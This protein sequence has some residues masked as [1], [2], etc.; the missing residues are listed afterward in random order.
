[1]CAA[2]SHVRFTPN[3]DR[4]SE[5]PQKAMSALPPKADMCGALV[6]VCFGPIADM[7]RL[8]DQL[9]CAGEQWQWNADAECLG[10]FQIDG[11]FKLG[12]L[13]DREVPTHCTFEDSV[14][15]CCAVL[16]LASHVRSVAHQSTGRD[17]VFL[18]VDHDQSV[19]GREGD[20]LCPMLQ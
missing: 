13:L 19:L 11:Q 10:R 5:I 17:V 14:N 6:H 16:I 7:D 4:E 2:T 12:G 3:S 1:M 9:I 8:L 20:N 15:V 18:T